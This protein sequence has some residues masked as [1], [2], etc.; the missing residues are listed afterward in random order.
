MAVT[1]VWLL[2]MRVERLASVLFTL[3]SLLSMSE[4][5]RIDG[6]RTPDPGRSSVSFRGVSP[7]RH[8]HDPSRL[9]SAPRERAPQNALKVDATSVSS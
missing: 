6:D 7:E 4:V 9:D 2:F 3:Y 1:M 8:T 5:S